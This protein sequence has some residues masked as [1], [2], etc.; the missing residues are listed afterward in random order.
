MIQVYSRFDSKYSAE[1]FFDS[2]STAIFIVVPCWFS[3]G[4]KTIF[5]FKVVKTSI[6]RNNEH[7]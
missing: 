5:K 3:S 6:D 4:R 1:Y 2:M 7:C